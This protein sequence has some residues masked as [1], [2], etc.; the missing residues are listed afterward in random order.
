MEDI[1]AT[2]F[3]F[4]LSVGW[5]IFQK[6]A[7]H[8]ARW[9]EAISV[10]KRVPIIRPALPSSV[11][12]NQWSM[13]S[14]RWKISKSELSAAYMWDE[15]L[16]W[17]CLLACIILLCYMRV[18]ML[19]KHT[20]DACKFV[21][22]VYI[23]CYLLDIHNWIR[24][25]WQLRSESWHVAKMLSLNGNRTIEVQRRVLCVKLSNFVQYSIPLRDCTIQRQK[26]ITEFLLFIE[27]MP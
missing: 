8:A 1:Y 5:I 12:M 26:P 3:F 16:K 21:L 19:Q 10:V 9:N 7:N 25:H 24:S 17:L 20:K 2:W 11:G 13:M 27:E 4:C 18:K 23:Y 6:V 15:Y 14:L 22:C